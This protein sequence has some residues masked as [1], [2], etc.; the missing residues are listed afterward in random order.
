MAQYLKQEVAARIRQAALEVF[1]ARGFSAASMADIA[2]A[3]D[4]STG[5]LYR[6]FAS[7]EVLLEEVV[8]P[9]LPERLL[10]LLR[11]RVRA[12]RGQR[13]IDPHAPS[14]AFLAA[15]EELLSFSIENRLALVF[16]LERAEGSVY[17]GFRGRLRRRL[18]QL[19]LMHARELDP[20]RVPTPST[21][22]VIRLVYDGFVAAMARILAEHDDA[23]RIREAVE[24]YGAYHLAGLAHLLS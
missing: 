24:R 14:P 6:Y 4:V 18:E 7:K 19:A 12:S 1:A 11:R 22:L 17:A 20:T 16:L 10:T 23:A 8:P 5:N 13:E 21:R 9:A 3:A 2:R 15:S